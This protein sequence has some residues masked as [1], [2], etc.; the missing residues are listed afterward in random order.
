MLLLLQQQQDSKEDGG[1][2]NGPRVTLLLHQQLFDK[3]VQLPNAPTVNM[4]KEKLHKCR[5]IIL[6]LA[7]PLCSSIRSPLKQEMELPF[8]SVSFCLNKSFS[9]SALTSSPSCG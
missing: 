5:S 4:D 7:S 6:Q 8:H 1:S 3:A 9:L 2:R